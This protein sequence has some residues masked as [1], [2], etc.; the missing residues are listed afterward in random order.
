M[1][2]AVETVSLDERRFAFGVIALGRMYSWLDGMI[3]SEERTFL[4]TR[5]YLINRSLSSLR[6]LYSAIEDLAELT[7]FLL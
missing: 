2:L 4:V 6:A 5:S 1:S 3:M 7:S